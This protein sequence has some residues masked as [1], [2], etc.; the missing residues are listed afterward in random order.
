VTAI[1]NAL[2]EIKASKPLSKYAKRLLAHVRPQLRF[3]LRKGKAAD[4]KPGASRVGGDPDLP[5]G[6]AWPIGP[7]FDGEAPMDFLAQL[8]LDAISPRDVD[9]LLPRSGVLAFFL[10]QNYQGC[11]VIHG[12]HDA[13]V[14]VPTPGRKKTAKPPRW[15]GFDV[16]AEMVLPPPWSQ[17]VSSAARSATM[18]NSR[19]GERGKGP[20]LVELPAPA[21]QAYCAIYERW[22]E[23]VGHAQHGMFGYERMMENAQQADELV[24]LR[25][26]HHGFSEY[27]FVELVSVY[28]FITEE[29]LTGRQF[30]KVEA[31]CGSTI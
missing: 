31:F 13:V 6:T 19:T 3:T 20:T 24:L 27:D 26:D 10:A 18:W 16:T 25:L 21:H 15:G 14:R 29:A 9:G 22:L 1:E 5:S 8:D 2:D 30:D 17:F 23:A 12:E 4:T 28:W 11:A 7:G